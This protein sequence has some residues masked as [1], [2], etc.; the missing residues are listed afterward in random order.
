M[1]EE[2]HEVRRRQPAQR[3]SYRSSLGTLWAA[4]VARRALGRERRSAALGDERQN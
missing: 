2:V 3:R 4:R 1:F